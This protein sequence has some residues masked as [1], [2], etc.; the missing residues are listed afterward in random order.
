MSTETFKCSASNIFNGTIISKEK[1]KQ[2]II[3]HSYSKE[4]QT[5]NNSSLESI[6]CGKLLKYSIEL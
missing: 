5:G 2:P 4:E 1:S 6:F 3:F